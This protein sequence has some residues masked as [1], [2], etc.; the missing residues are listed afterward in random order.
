M[1]ASSSTSQRL[2]AMYGV[3]A[4]PN[5]HQRREIFGIDLERSLDQR[6]IRVA[7][8]Y[9]QSAE[10]QEWRRQV[11]DTKVRLRFDPSNIGYVSV[12]IGER[13]LTV[14]SV[15]DMFRGLDLETWM[16]SVRDLRRRHA[17]N[18]KIYEHIALAAIR[19]IS[20]MADDAMRRVSIDA[21]RPTAEELDREER[22]L[23]LGFEI[24]DD[25]AL[26]SDEGPKTDLLGGGIPVAS[27]RPPV[28]PIQ[29]SRPAA[30]DGDYGLED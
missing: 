15:R 10:I 9:Y 20:Q 21:T 13:W 22:H 17:K 14:P 27:A 28:T 24:T 25:N 5:G 19:A 11:G 7:G 18:A 30:D 2:T 3:D 12:W 8:V 6:G 23:L 29:P 26:G 16:E 4:P 1:S